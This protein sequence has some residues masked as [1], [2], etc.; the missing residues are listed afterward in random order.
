MNKGKWKCDEFY[1][2]NEYQLCLCRPRG[3]T[4][5]KQPWNEQKG[6]V[7][8]HTTPHFI[9]VVVS[10][11]SHGMSREPSPHFIRVVVSYKSS[12][13]LV[14]IEV[15]RATLLSGWR[16]TV[17]VHCRRY[18]DTGCLHHTHSTATDLSE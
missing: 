11:N 3:G 17:A 16:S 12:F 10:Y 4:T 1:I 6:L 15:E 14:V 2:A 7:T 9:Q 13:L 5:D 18:A 8:H